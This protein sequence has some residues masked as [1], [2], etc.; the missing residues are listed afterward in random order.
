MCGI[1]GIINLNNPEPY[2]DAVRRMVDILT[3][4]GP[5]GKGEYFKPG[6]A[7][8]HTRLKIIDLSEAGNQPMSDP[9]GRYTIVYNGEVYNFKELQGQLMGGFK[10]RSRTDTE[11]VLASYIRWGEKCLEKFNGM[12]AFA[13]WDEYNREL[14][15]ARDRLGVKPLFYADLNGIFVF[16]SEQKAIL[17]SGLIKPEINPE[18]LYH[19]LSFY[20]FPEPSTIYKGI[21]SLPAGFYAR[22]KDGQFKK[23]RWWGPSFDKKSA[24]SENKG[25]DALRMYLE[26]S[27]RLRQVADVPVGCFLS[28]GVDSTAVSALMRNAVGQNFKTYTIAFEDD[29]NNAIDVHYAKLAS[30]RIGTVH[31]YANISFDE[32]DKNLPSILWRLEE[33]GWTSIE[34]WFVSKLAREGITVALAGVG[35][36]ELFAGYFPYSHVYR[37]ECLKSFLG[38]FAGIA[39]DLARAIDRIIPDDFKQNPPLSSLHRFGMIESLDYPA[40]HFYLRS[41]FTDDEKLNLLTPDF[42]NTVK[43]I[44]SL[45]YVRQLMKKVRGNSFIDMFSLFDIQNYLSADLLRHTDSMSMSHSLEVRIPLLDYRFVETA[46]SLEDDRKIHNGE[47]KYVFKKAIDNL[48]PDEIKIRPKTGFIFPMKTWMKSRYKDEI[49]SIFSSRSFES[50]GI[51]NIKHVKQLYDKYISGDEN[52]WLRLWTILSVEI[53]ARMYIDSNGANP[54]EV[55]F[56]HFA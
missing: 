53:W 7:L 4:R 19:Y 47:S 30:D 50:R 40:S 56:S 20:H 55:S 16:A 11:V 34:S 1:A 41:A 27:T 36:D 9:S 31:K 28:G 42:I 37:A 10:F 52:Q 51:F 15:L 25:A 17:A 46:L 18:S 29:P 49:A 43:G 13:I 24:L 35:G 38:P 2:R 21:E 44:S 12:F 33:P 45:E 5:D 6:V 3:P 22:F 14:F 26:D 48:I 8:G 23:T 39:G 54:G 32:I